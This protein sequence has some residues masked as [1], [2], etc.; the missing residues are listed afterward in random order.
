[1]KRSSFNIFFVYIILVKGSEL[2]KALEERYKENDL[3]IIKFK[4]MDFKAD[5][6]HI[7]RFFMDIDS[8]IVI[9]DVKINYQEKSDKQSRP[10]KTGDG[11]ITVQGIYSAV[12]SLKL[13]G[14]VILFVASDLCLYLFLKI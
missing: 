7:E 14:K 4:D 13:N 8:K 2:K 6:G 5:R 1:M 9:K 10:M 11:S 12:E 3:I